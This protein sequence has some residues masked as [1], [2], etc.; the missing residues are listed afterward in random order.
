MYSLVVSLSRSGRHSSC[1]STRQKTRASSTSL[2]S[3]NLKAVISQGT[4]PLIEPGLGSTKTL[5]RG[6]GALEI[7][8]KFTM[9]M[10]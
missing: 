10:D 2:L 9:T 7:A 6:Q 3:S 5:T 1:N 4:R 8:L